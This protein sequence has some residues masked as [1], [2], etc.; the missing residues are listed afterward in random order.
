MRELKE[1]Y[2]LH[3]FTPEDVYEM[4]AKGYRD[5][6]IVVLVDGSRY[7]LCFYDSFRLSQD[8]EDEKAIFSHGL[9]VVEDLTKEIIESTVMQMVLNKYFETSFKFER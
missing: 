6:V 9:V 3:G 1:I 8:L 5:D 4:N 2:F 7:R